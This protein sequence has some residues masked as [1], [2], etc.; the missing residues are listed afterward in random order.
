MFSFRGAGILLILATLAACEPDKPAD[1]RDLPIVYNGIDRELLDV[2]LVNMHVSLTGGRTETDVEEYAKCAVA[3]YALNRGYGFARH[4]RTNVTNEA[5][6]WAADAVY[7]ISPTLPQGLRT[8]DADITVQNCVSL[9]I[10]T[11]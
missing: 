5:G 10:P 2:D 6:I 9:G 3:Q 8:I 1:S 11:V 4:V 7:T